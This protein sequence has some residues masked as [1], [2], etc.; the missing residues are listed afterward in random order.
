MQRKKKITTW[1]NPQTYK[2]IKK[3]AKNNNWTKSKIT[4]F[5]LNKSLSNTPTFKPTLS[6]KYFRILRI[7]LIQINNSLN[8]HSSLI[9][10]GY[11]NLNQM[12]KCL[13]ILLKHQELSSDLVEYLTY[14][15]NSVAN[16]KGYFQIE[17]KIEAKVNL[18]WSELNKE[19]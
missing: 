17:K 7:Q 4:R 9:N 2:Q 19:D 18:I 3:L 1:V 13:N 14:S 15:V 6:I 10:H 11:I 8:K 16:L 5:I 12:T